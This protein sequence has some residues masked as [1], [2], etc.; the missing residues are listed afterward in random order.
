MTSRPA[1]RTPDLNHD[2]VVN[3]TDLG[4]LLGLFRTALPNNQGDLNY[5]LQLNGLDLVIMLGAW[6]TVP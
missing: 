3:G 1:P 2:G 6:G 5:D 4:L